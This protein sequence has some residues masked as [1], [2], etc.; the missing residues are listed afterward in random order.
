[1]R[2][3][4]D[5]AVNSPGLLLLP[6]IGVWGADFSKLNQLFITKVSQEH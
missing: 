3:F 4:V 5:S 1:M 2:D 6:S